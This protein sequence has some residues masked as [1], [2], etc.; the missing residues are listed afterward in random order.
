MVKRMM[1][2]GNSMGLILNR[3]L[4]DLLK[5]QSNTPLDI[6]TDGRRIIITPLTG[7]EMKSCNLRRPLRG[8]A[9][10]HAR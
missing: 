7:K 2:V 8:K 9:R 3:S 6:S 5:I 4:L 10:P 1:K